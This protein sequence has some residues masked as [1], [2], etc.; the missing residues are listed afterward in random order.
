[1]EK[2]K[3]AAMTFGEYFKQHRIQLKMTLRAFCREHKL[4]PGYISKLERGRASAPRDRTKL[5]RF[6]IYL[7]LDSGEVEGFLDLA[8]ISARR[9]PADLT[10]AELVKR[11]PILFKVARSTTPE[12][13]EKNLRA[14]AELIRESENV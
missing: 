13:L 11:L 10:E 4:D 14:L 1:M 2:L 12:K 7:D 9:I 8:A 6:A 3:R 5:I